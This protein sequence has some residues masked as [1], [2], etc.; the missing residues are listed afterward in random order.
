MSLSICPVAGV[1][2]NLGGV[3]GFF[4]QNNLAKQ[5]Q[6]QQQQEQPV[7]QHPVLLKV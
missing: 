7:E 2:W 3:I 6:Q 5:Q 1:Q 4:P